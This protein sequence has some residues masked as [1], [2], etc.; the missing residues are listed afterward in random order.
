VWLPKNGATPD[1]LLG[2]KWERIMDLWET[3]ITVNAELPDSL[4]ED[5]TLCLVVLG[6]QLNSDGTI[7]EELEERLK[8]ALS[9]SEKYPNAY[10]VCTGGG[11]ATENPDATEAGRMAGS[12]G[13][14]SLQNYCGGSVF[15]NGSEC[16]LYI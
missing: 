3:P 2:E 15:D 9:N 11:T 13:C 16:D 14:G 6:F 5:D 10:I 12:K 1:H 7:K 4:P 8:V